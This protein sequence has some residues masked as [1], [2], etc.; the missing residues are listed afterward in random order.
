MGKGTRGDFSEIPQ[1]DV[2]ALYGDDE[3]AIKATAK[4]MRAH[5]ETTGFLYV[6]GHPISIEQIESVREMSRKFF[7]LPE[8]EKLKLRIDKNFRGYLPFAGSTIVTSSVEKVTKPNQSESIFFMHEVATDDPRAL[9]GEPLQG[10]NQWPEENVLP[11]F[12]A[13]IEAYVDAMSTLGRK[14]ARAIAIALDL[15]A[16]SLQPFFADPTTFLRLLHY[17][18]Q[19]PKRGCSARPRILTTDSSPCWRR[20]MLAG[21]KC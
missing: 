1:L 7:A 3:N 14:M 11:G 12:R 15:P 16:D 6:V 10:P 9:A 13:T 17:P 2:S 21:W 4:E 19:P 20:T 18:P 8:D 5:L